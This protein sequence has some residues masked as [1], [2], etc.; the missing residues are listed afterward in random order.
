[1][2]TA[3]NKNQ[4]MFFIISKNA[5]YDIE[6]IQVT[7]ISKIPIKYVGYFKTNLFNVLWICYDDTQ[8]NPKVYYKIFQRITVIVR[9]Q[10]IR[11][12]LLLFRNVKH[13]IW[14]TIQNQQNQSFNSIIADRRSL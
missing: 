9:Y 2:I 7:P 10:S 6:Y 11:S 12:K 14:V 3:F 8:S 13:L 5:S 4:K 1:M